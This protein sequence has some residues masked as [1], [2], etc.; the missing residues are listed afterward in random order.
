MIVLV[1]G[2]RNHSNYALIWDTLDQLHAERGITRIVHGAGGNVD[3]SA[4]AWAKSRK[5]EVKPYPA[6][7]T[8]I[9]RPDAVIRIRRDGAKYDAKQGINRNQ[10]MLDKEDIA[11][12]VAFPGGPG[13]RDM[14]ARSRRAGI[15]VMAIPDPG[16]F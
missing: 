10:E 13:T 5:V 8:D 3:M 1:C 15:D 2:G 4:D 16:R 9:S 7:W 6:D 14:V 11:L 12:V